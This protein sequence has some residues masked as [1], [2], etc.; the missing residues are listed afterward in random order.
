MA[1]RIR[2][3]VDIGGTFTDVVIEGP[4]GMRSTKV[5]TTYAAPE[6]A[7][8]EG[9]ARVCALAG[10][11]PGQIDQIIH[12]TTLAT[13]ALIERRGA[14][15][16][17]VTT[18]GF[19]DVI[20]MRTESRFEQYDLNM[21][22]PEPLIPRERR[23]TLPERIDADGGVLTPLDVAAVE[24]LADEV[25]QGGYEAIAV[26]FLHAYANP[27]HER[28]VRDVLAARMPDAMI[29]LSSDVSPQMREYERFNTTIANAYIQP[30]MKSYLLRLR[31]RL[32]GEGAD[33]PIFLMHSG[34]GIM[35]LESAA[36][37]PVRLVESGPAGG[38]VFAADIAARHDLDRVLSFDMGG[39]TAKICLI[40]DQTPKTARVFEVA[41]SY[42]FKK[43]SG[44]PISIPVIDMVEIGAGGGS[45]AWVDAMNQIRVGPES[46]GSE[47]GPACYGRGGTRPAVTDADLTLGKLDPANFAG[48]TI[49]LDPA[50]SK[51]ALTDTLGTPLDMDAQEAAFGLAEV[52]DENMANAARVH[53]VENGEDLSTYTM[54]AFGGA[55]PLHAARL[56]EKLG[57]A[58]CLVPQGAGVGSAIGF[59]RAPFSFEANRTVFMP[60]AGFDPARVTDLFQEMEEEATAFVR[61]C[62]AQ[63]DVETAHRVYMRYRGQGWEIPVTLTADQAAK[64]DA[65]TLLSLFEAEYEKLFKRTVAGMVAEI[66]VWSVTA[67]T[68]QEAPPRIESAAT[69]HAT[70]TIGL[71]TRQLFDPALGTTTEAR[72]IDRGTLTTLQGPALVTEDETTIVVPTSRAVRTAPDGTLMVEATGEAQATEVSTVAYQVMWNRLISIVEEQAQAL[73]RTA[74][75]T[76]V[77]EAGDLS[78]GV[79][80]AAGDMLAQ[81]VTGT[82]G[83]V[84]AM[85]DAVGHFIRRIPEMAPGDVYIT[86]DPWEGTGHKHDITIVTPSFH[87][88]TLIGFFACTAH[89]TDIG[90]R[91][92]GADANDV[93]EEGLYLPIMPLMRAGEVDATLMALIRANV[94]EP[95]Q[96][97]GDIYALATC[98]DIGHAR[99]LEMMA[100]FGLSDLT[101]VSDFILTNSRDATLKAINALTP[102]QAKGHMRIDGYSAPIDLHVALS[103]ETDRITADWTGTS[104]VDRKGIN[105]PLVYTK[106]Y[107]C[108]ALKCAIAPEIPNNAA[109]LAPFE[110]TAPEGTIVNAVF[111]APVALRH[112]IGHM[113]P[114]TVYDALDKLLPDTVP[115]EGAGCL[116][117]FQLSLKPTGPE[118]RRAEVLTFNS[119]GS[120]A[121]PTLDGMNATAFPSGVMT[122]PVEATEQVGPVIIWRK[123]LRPDSGGAGTRRGGLGQFMDVGARKG[124]E[125]DISAMLDRV[126][127]PARGRKGGADGGATFIRRDDGTEMQGKGRQHVPEGTIVQMGFPG[128]AG[129]GD[130]KARD[131]DAVRKDLAGGY[132]SADAARNVYGLGEDD[133]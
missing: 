9:M 120:G 107:A 27:T 35:S 96:L 92:F 66:T 129:Y 74:F 54:I 114:D 89:V 46:A 37:F 84:N 111:P 78:A 105:V 71:P 47:P 115:V 131:R 59:L 14:H 100:E 104:G 56:C 21:T 63:A 32:A 83:H 13:N 48:G 6:D 17:F 103:I 64:P 49:P 41:R 86:N 30:L 106:A 19:R 40:K 16:A 108:Y 88:K 51:A 24:S 20:E 65:D 53:A 102:G 128:G 126:H 76:S 123:E 58:K 10:V 26:G 122:M 99:L 11:E 67:S 87:H 45:L 43:G 61:S 133:A 72:V 3:G 117:N 7:I 8:V 23:F 109:S 132:I 79:Y 5:L 98:N 125:F 127:H 22:L 69:A 91:G 80:N 73:V 119:G 42:R 55:A 33:C 94:R 101:G 28:A 39:T 34:G 85:A 1:D 116:C 77:R 81:A 110:V 124:H 25:A 60:I 95:D 121:R 29:S 44:M 31:D 2:L 118:G 68:R 52:V 93:H 113:V 62:D 112:V 75:S 4:F 70:A 18:Q 50:A 12:G 82:P 90:G 130:P 15:M 97:V 38:A 57:I 36:D